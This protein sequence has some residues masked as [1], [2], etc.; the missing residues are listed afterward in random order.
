[1]ADIFPNIFKG[2]SKLK[3]T[4]QTHKTK[5]FFLSLHLYI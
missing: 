4:L 2:K 5:L 3:K 1:M